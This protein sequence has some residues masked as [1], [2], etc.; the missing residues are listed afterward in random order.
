ML[1]YEVVFLSYKDQKHIAIGVYMPG[2]GGYNWEYNGKRYHMLEVTGD[3]W[4]LGECP[5]SYVG[6]T[7]TVYPIGG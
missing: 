1:N 4:K 5:P 6:L 2:T 3:Y 7:P